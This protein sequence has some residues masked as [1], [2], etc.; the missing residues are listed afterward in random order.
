MEMRNEAAAK[1]LLLIFK[2]LFFCGCIVSAERRGPETRE[3]DWSFRTEQRERQKRDNLFARVVGNGNVVMD[4]TSL[5]FPGILLD[6]CY[7]FSFNIVCGIN[8]ASKYPFINFV[9]FKK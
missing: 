2:L 4:D 8:F 5:V 3:T 6:V 1:K 7:R 9:S